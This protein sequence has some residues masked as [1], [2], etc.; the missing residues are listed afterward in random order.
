MTMAGIQVGARSRR[1]IDTTESALLVRLRKQGHL[2]LRLVLQVRVPEA[3]GYSPVEGFTT[4]IQLDSAEGIRRVKAAL[5]R[6][7][8]EL[9]RQEGRQDGRQ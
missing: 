6:A 3:G 9:T 4:P 7:V 1:K 2:S 8:G 5:Q